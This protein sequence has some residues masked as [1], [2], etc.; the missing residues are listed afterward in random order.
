ME[1]EAIKEE[2]LKL[3]IRKSDGSNKNISSLNV[4][5]IDSKPKTTSFLDCCCSIFKKRTTD[6]Y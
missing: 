4:G 2:K 5:L 1:K 3:E 6:D